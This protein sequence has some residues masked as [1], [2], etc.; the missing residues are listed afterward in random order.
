MATT[1]PIVIPSRL[2]D[3]A[4]NPLTADMLSLI[5]Q[6]AREINTLR[7]RVTALEKK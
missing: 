1:K 3:G 6:M 7:D 2:T 5:S 4:G